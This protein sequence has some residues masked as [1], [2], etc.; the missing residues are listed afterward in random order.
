MKSISIKG[1]NKNVTIKNLLSGISGLSLL[2]LLTRNI[3]NNNIGLIIDASASLILILFFYLMYDKLSQDNTSYFFI[4]LTIIIHNSYLYGTSFLGVNFDHYMHFLGGFTIAIMT[5][6]IFSL[7]LSKTKRVYLLII[8]AMGLG[9]IGEVL[10]W[11]GYNLLGTGDG[12]LLYGLGD[13]GE[14]NNA[15]KDMIFN[16]LGGAVMGLR[17]LFRK[18]RKFK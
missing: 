12:F 2:I 8:A 14:W 7:N 16:G 13:L 9:S 18:E 6:R 17:A 4:I 1:Y 11:T 15:T 10:E 3:I 5:D